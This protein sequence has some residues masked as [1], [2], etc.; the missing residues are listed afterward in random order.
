MSNISEYLYEVFAAILFCVGITFAL[1]LFNSSTAQNNAATQ[2]TTVKE[3]VAES[4]DGYQG[5][6]L[7]D[8]ATVIT[9]IMATGGT[10]PTYVD[11]VE[12]PQ[13]TIADCADSKDPSRIANFVE[14]S[15]TYLVTY[16]EDPD[17]K[18]VKAVKYT[19]Q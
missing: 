17:S 9:N 13:A 8:G 2:L 6:N 11:D 19:K 12:I 16:T 14:T 4:E 18:L 15:G 7:V 5:D 1:N 10:I 3:N